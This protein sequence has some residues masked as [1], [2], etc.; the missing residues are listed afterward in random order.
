MAG[1]AAALAAGCGS[2]GASGAVGSGP[3]ASSPT[4]E[5]SAGPTPT[6]GASGTAAP[7]EPGT[8]SEIP[9]GRALPGDGGGPVQ[10]T[11]REE[12]RRALAQA[13]GWRSG[14]YLINA[15]GQNVNDEGVPSY[16]VMV[17]IDKAAA[18]AV[19]RL[20]IDPWGKVTRTEEV[21]GD[22]IISFVDQYTKRVPYDVIDSDQ[23]VAIGKPA[24]GAKY[25]LL[26]TKDP[27]II[28]SS[29]KITGGDLHWTYMLFY[30]S[31]AEYVSAIIE[32]I[33]GAVVTLK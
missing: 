9:P 10:Y 13:S 18:D 32:P 6:A 1:L 29:N 26:K 28:L 23:V 22:G 12:W 3:A 7:S 24:L 31:T 30:N 17:F 20:E 8:T 27:S 5:G 4:P 15:S 19:L 14:A 16:W 25:N 2:S 11:F 33:T 21:T